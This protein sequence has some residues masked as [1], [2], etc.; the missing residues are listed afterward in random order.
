VRYPNP[1]PTKPTTTISAQMIDTLMEYLSKMEGV[2][3]TSFT[4]LNFSRPAVC[5]SG[6][7]GEQ[8]IVSEDTAKQLIKESAHA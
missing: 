1:P 3:Y 4:I 7:H 2:K 5:F 8:K 6:E